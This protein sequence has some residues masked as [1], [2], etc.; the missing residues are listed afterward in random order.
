MLEGRGR[1]S[2]CVRDSERDEMLE[3]RVIERVCV[4]VRE[5]ERDEIMEGRV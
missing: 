5:S 3:G 1:E 4:C 2:V